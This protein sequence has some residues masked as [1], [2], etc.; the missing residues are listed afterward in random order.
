M[1]A[2]EAAARRSVDD[3][4]VLGLLV[5]AKDRSGTIDYIKAFGKRATKPEEKP[6]ETDTV[7]LLASMTKLM[8]TIAAL[9]VVERGL[10]KL[11]DDVAGLLPVLAKQEILTGVAEDG[12]PIMKKRRNP[13]TLRQ[14]LTH[15]F[16]G[17]YDAMSPD[18]MRYKEHHNFPPTRGSTIDEIFGLPLV[19]QPGEGWSY[20]SGL[21]WAG[22][23]VE[24]LSGL[25]LED[26]MK[27]HI[28][29]PL[30][31]NDMTFWPDTRPDIRE[32]LASMTFRDEAT[33]KA[34]QSRKPFKLSA[35]VE[36]ACGGQGAFA[37]MTDYTGILHS[38]LVDD[39]RLLKKETTEM[40]FK[41][42]LSAA[43]KEALVAN[44]KHPEWAVGHYPDTEEYDWGLGGVLVDGDK[45]PYRK[46]GAMLWGGIANLAW[47]LDRTTG[48]C[49][50][51]GSQLLPP[52][53]VQIEELME[54]FEAGFYSLTK[55]KTRL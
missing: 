51:F 9:Q 18:I 13:I 23:I 34:V 4:V 35:G 40:M 54:A 15:S 22:K 24:I 25:K 20:G 10:I 38:L 30:G 14:L 37:T 7:F 44:F 53:D 29:G 47:F 46:R 6:V 5:S 52:A 45:H 33:G 2:F 26:Y 27:Q 19:H 12:V 1:E 43:S 36:E 50:V 48:V 41:P 17:C 16:G 42:Q 39:E 32:R 21:D 8:T 55:I 3:G 11:D 31:L 28:W 49:G